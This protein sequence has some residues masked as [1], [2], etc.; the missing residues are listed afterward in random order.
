MS[1]CEQPLNTHWVHMNANEWVL[2][3]PWTPI[4][5]SWMPLWVSVNNHW[6]RMTTFESLLNVTH[7]GVI[8]RK[9]SF[10]SE[11]NTPWT[12]VSAL[13][14]LWVSIEHS[15]SACECTWTPLNEY[16]IGPECLWVCVNSIQ[17]VRTSHEHPLSAHECLWVSI[18]RVWICTSRVVN[19]KIWGRFKLRVWTLVSIKILY[20]TGKNIHTFLGSLQKYVWYSQKYGILSNLF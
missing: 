17:W 1:D 9:F 19:F 16:W 2:N 4:E 18:R 14:C 15:L 10:L 3:T 20:V 8:I 6:L 13:E 11:L 7:H 5:R 12:L